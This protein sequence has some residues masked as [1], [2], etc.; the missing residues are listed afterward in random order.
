MTFLPRASTEG[1]W[2]F[3]SRQRLWLGPAL[4]SAPVFYS[5]GLEPKRFTVK[6]GAVTQEETWTVLCSVPS[7]YSESCI[8]S[9]LNSISRNSISKHHSV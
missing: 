4:L 1:V 5:E 7:T 8:F 6:R 3:P 9:S 2:R